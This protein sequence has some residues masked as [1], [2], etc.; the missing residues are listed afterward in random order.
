MPTMEGE[1]LFGLGSNDAGASVVSLYEAFTILCEHKPNYNLVFLA[2]AEEEI[3]GKNGIKRVLSDAKLPDFTFGIVGEPTGMQP[4]I[5]G[6]GLMVLDCISYGVSG[7]AARNEGVNAITK[8][9]DDIH[10]F[11]TYQFPK[12]T[13]LLGPVKMTV[14]MIQAGTQHNVIPDQCHFTVDVRTNECYTNEEIFNT[15]RQHVQCE[16]KPRRMELGSSFISPSHPFVASTI[17]MGKT[18][19]GSPTLSDQVFMKFPTVKMGPGESERSHTADEYIFLPEIIE[20]IET[21]VTL[22]DN[23]CIENTTLL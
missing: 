11:N 6:K 8:A 10:W 2:S 20:A 19:Y 17:Q 21:Y 16:V 22:L 1:K 12:Q 15:I 18:P 7:H 3:S 23:L 9:M 13:K 4:A 14:T 5:A